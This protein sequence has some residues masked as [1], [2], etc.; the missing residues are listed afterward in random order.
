MLP[1]EVRYLNVVWSDPE[2]VIKLECSRDALEIEQI[3]SG[4]QVET[5]TFPSAHHYIGVCI[6]YNRLKH[7]PY[8]EL[9]DGGRQDLMALKVP[10]SEEV[11][12]IQSSEWDEQGKRH[13]SELYRT[14]GRAGLIIQGQKLTIENNTF[15]FSVQDLEYYLSDFKNNLWMLILNNSSAAKG[16]VN[17]EMP[18]CFN[19]ETLGLFHDFIQSVEKI[20]QKPGM[21]LIESQGKLPLR[22]VRPVPRSFREYATQPNAKSLTSRTY[23]ESYDTAENQF[24]HYCVKRVFYVLKSLSRVADAQ[25]RSYTQRITQEKE[26]VEVLQ[27]SNV[28]QVDSRVYDNEISKLER[29]LAALAQSLSALVIGGSP[30]AG[31]QPSAEYGTYSVQLEPCRNHPRAFF[32]NRLDGYD[33]QKRHGTYLV[34]KFPGGIDLSTIHSSL[35]RCDI[36]ISGRYVKDKKNEENGNPHFELEF[37]QIES[38]SIEQHPWKQELSKLIDHRKQLERNNWKVPL[39]REELKDRAMESDVSKRKIA[40]YDVMV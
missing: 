36:G 28:K 5:T 6:K 18:D 8:F 1:I 11:W 26:S 15:N 29:D 38:A 37:L 23:L 12:W 10:G 32:A 25:S 20:V 4:W 31:S 27:Q 33:F 40:L 35:R 17:K 39:T 30:V 22:K 3:P 21:V 34:V 13:L 14:A 16:S 24:I 9:A 7:T 2:T 19:D